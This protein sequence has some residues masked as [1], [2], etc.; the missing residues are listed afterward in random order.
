MSDK[1][2]RSSERQIEELQQKMDE[3]QSMLQVAQTAQEAHEETIQHMKAEAAREREAAREQAAK[4]RAEDRT[5][6]LQLVNT[7]Q[8]TLTAGQQQAQQAQQQAQQALQQALAQQQAPPPPPPP[9]PQKPTSTTNLVVTQDVPEIPVYGDVKVARQ[10]SSQ[11]SLQWCLDVKK[12]FNA[13]DQ[14]YASLDAADRTKKLEAEYARSLER[15][16]NAELLESIQLEI[17]ATD[18]KISNIKDVTFPKVYKYIQE[19]LC[20]NKGITS[21]IKFENLFSEFALQHGGLWIDQDSKLTL[22]ITLYLRSLY[23]FLY[24]PLQCI[25]DKD[26]LA[27][28]IKR[29]NAWQSK[30]FLLQF[31]RLIEHDILRQLWFETLGTVNVSTE[32]IENTMNTY[33]KYVE[34]QKLRI[35]GSAPSLLTNADTK[36]TFKPRTNVPASGS[37]P[38]INTVVPNN[39]TDTEISNVPTDF[40]KVLAA[41]LATT[42]KL[43]AIDTSLQ[44]L[45]QREL[46]RDILSYH[47]QR[48]NNQFNQSPSQYQC[49]TCG[50]EGH[51]A[52]QCK[53]GTRSRSTEKYRSRSRSRSY[54]PH[55][56]RSR[57]R[58][59]D[60]HH[61]R[62]RSH[63]RDKHR[64]SHH[65]KDRD[66]RSKSYDRRSRSRS[67][68]HGKD[69]DP[70]RRSR[71]RTRDNK[72]SNGDKHV[73]RS[74]SRHKSSH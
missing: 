41:H 4:E 28:F 18:N 23:R 17:V 73:E 24:L 8:T 40:N 11:I 13:F 70:E 51:F 1:R 15:C 56:S 63:S 49:W 44:Q 19:E 66:R 25:S 61:H 53:R 42:Q 58:S 55:R 12:S 22:A 16:F 31:N 72:D 67:Y 6:F 71:S 7:L 38:K 69:K 43:D 68:H 46:N 3:L 39:V 36:F 33:I 48:A 47:Q 21:V 60:R 74:H 57:S 62:H 65:S 20:I 35:H 9:P 26:V 14:L 32:T 2:S 64:S 30:N 50:K 10:P 59:R 5:V 37:V 45:A 27:W 34:S 29:E 52:N 54:T